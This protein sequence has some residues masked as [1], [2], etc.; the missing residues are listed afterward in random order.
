MSWQVNRRKTSR[1][2]SPSRAWS[3]AR[4]PGKESF[5][6]VYG[7]H[8]IH[9]LGVEELFDHLPTVAAILFSWPI[10]GVVRLDSLERPARAIVSAGAHMHHPLRCGDSSLV[11]DARSS[12]S[13]LVLFELSSVND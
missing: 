13:R 2:A 6:A 4:N 8:G 7:A 3:R 11:R 9:A 1:A 12:P 10:Q 5:G